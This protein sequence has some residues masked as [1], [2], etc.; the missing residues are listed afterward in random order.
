MKILHDVL[1]KPVTNDD[2]LPSSIPSASRSRSAA[3]RKLGRVR[4]QPRFVPDQQN[5]QNYIQQDVWH[6]S[7]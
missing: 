2:I 3:G 5:D 6:I 7:R 1:T 4:T